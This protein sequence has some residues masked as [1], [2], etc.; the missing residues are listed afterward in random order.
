MDIQLV[1]M[2]YGGVRIMLEW[3]MNVKKMMEHPLQLSI[4]PP[5][6]PPKKNFHIVQTSSKYYTSI[7][8]M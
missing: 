3:I 5:P 6:F 8:V 1:F 7:D 4:I 2:Q